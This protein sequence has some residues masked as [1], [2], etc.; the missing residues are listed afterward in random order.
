MTSSIQHN[1]THFAY[2]QLKKHTQTRK[3]TKT[4]GDSDGVAEAKRPFTSS[5]LHEPLTLTKPAEPKKTLKR[6]TNIILASQVHHTS[7]A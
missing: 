7:S 6:D 2:A 1:N 3:L 5:R 4:A